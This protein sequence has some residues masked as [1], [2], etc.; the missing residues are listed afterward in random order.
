LTLPVTFN[1]GISAGA[2]LVA[3]VADGTASYV[4]E[5]TFH[6]ILVDGTAADFTLPLYIT[7]SVP[8]TMVAN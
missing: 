5:G 7:G 6:V 4:V 1:I 8:A 2:A 3:A